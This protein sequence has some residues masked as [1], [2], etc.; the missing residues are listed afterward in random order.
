MEGIVRLFFVA[1]KYLISHWGLL[2]TLI[3]LAFLIQKVRFLPSILAFV[4]NLATDAV[5]WIVEGVTS[6]LTA[7]TGFLVG[8]L[9]GFILTAGPSVIMGFLWVSIILGSA[10]N[11]ILR[12]LTIPFAFIF[13]FVWG[14]FPLPLPIEFGMESLGSKPGPSNILCIA[15]IIGAILIPVI[16][17]FLFWL[18]ATTFG[19]SG[20]FAASDFCT[21]INDLL[22]MIS[23]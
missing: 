21:W 11:V 4:V 17:G 1:L 2:L 3:V 19:P 6:G 15:V 18:I 16:F 22:V 13:G 8:A 12:V 9:L 7:G 23:S 10:A 14:Y 20:A 5:N